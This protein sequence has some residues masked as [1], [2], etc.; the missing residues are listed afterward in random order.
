MSVIQ[1]QLKER[2]SR[3]QA[4]QWLSQNYYIFPELTNDNPV[5]RG[6]F[7]D[8][9]FVLGLDGIVYFGNCVEPGITEQELI[10][11]TNMAIHG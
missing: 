1:F 8:W 2:A 4:M 11:F 6:V 10:D 5:I 9:M 7:H 3:V